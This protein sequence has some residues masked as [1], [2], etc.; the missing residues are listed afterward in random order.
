[1]QRRLPQV[2]AALLTGDIDWRRAKTIADGT[3]HLPIGTARDVADEILE[4]ASGLTTGQLGAR[5]RGLCIEADPDE[6]D[7][8][9]RQSVTDRRIA[10]QPTETGTCHLFGLD[11]PPHRVAAATARI[12]QLARSLRGPDE[13]RS[14]DQLRAD[15]LL[16]LLEGTTTTTATGTTT[17]TGT[18]GTG[19]GRRGVVDIHVD[20]T[21]LTALADHPEELAGYG[22]VIADIARQV[23]DQQSQAEWRYTVTDPDTGQPIHNGVTRRRPTTNERRHIEARNPT[24]IFPGCRIPATNCDLDHRIPYSEGGPTTITHLAPLCPHDHNVIRHRHQWRYQPLPNGDHQWTSPLG[25]TYTT[26]GTTNDT[27]LASSGAPP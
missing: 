1:M 11:L 2:R 22:P 3:L 23:T 13:G 25:H 19:S 27:H 8:R 18:N 17:G 26:N 7:D 20:L 12:N 16:D 21:T 14:M 15:V 10:T 24:C 5:I 4:T 6:A 9:Y